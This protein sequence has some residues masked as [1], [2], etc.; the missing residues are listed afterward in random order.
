MRAVPFCRIWLEISVKPLILF[1]NVI[2]NSLS[3]SGVAPKKGP[4]ILLT[5]LKKVI[6]QKKALSENATHLFGSRWGFVIVITECF[7]DTLKIFGQ[8]EEGLDL[9]YIF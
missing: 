4:G 1:K 5:V 8:H 7:E 3:L 2:D 6:N 9:F